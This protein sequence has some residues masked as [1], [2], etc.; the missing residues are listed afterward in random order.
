MA[1]GTSN[2]TAL[3]YVL[4]VTPGTTPATPTLKEI[5][6]LSESI[7]DNIQYIRSQ[8]IRADRNNMDVVPVSREVAGDINFEL[9]YAAVNEDWLEAVVQGTFSTGTLKNG[10]TVRSY[11]IQKHM[12]DA[13][14]APGV[15]TNHVG[16]QIGGLT[17]D[18]NQGQI[19]QGK[20]SVMGFSGATA[21]AQIAGAVITAPP[22]TASMT[23]SNNVAA[24]KEN[25]VA[26]T[27]QYQ[28]ISLN[29]QNNLRAIKVIGALAP[30]AV[31]SGWLDITGSFELY[32]TTR[33]MLDRYLNNT[34]WA[35]YWEAVDGATKYTF[36]LPKIKIESAKVVSGGANQD[37]MLSA[38]YRAIYDGTSTSMITIVKV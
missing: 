23:A 11:T 6:Y 12:Q 31:N 32:F 15:F 2:R 18:F 37:L 17:L 38:T 35:L 34:S 25:T 16:C 22:T 9:A 20:W 19:V 30:V 7:V 4:E 24:I 33:T 21:V 5:N 27:E 36:N 26:T 10:T 1:S 28:K 13:G 8:H 14:S 3:R 29:I